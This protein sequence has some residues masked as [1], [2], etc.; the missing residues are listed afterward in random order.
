MA[1]KLLSVSEVLLYG[2]HVTDMTF[3]DPKGTRDKPVAAKYFVRV[4]GF[5]Y[6]GGYYAMDA[7]VIMLLKGK[8][9]DLAST[10]APKDVKD[11]FATDIKVWTAEK[12]DR[13]A[14]LDELTGTIEDILLDIELGGGGRVS[15]GRVSGGRVSGGRVSGG[16]VSGGRVS[17]GRVSG[18]KDD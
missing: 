9:A 17:G 6:E 7:P 1:E 14:R 5:G 18:G 15:G 8:G 10:S 13:S 2:E 3:I 16:R 11:A 12:S 4:Y